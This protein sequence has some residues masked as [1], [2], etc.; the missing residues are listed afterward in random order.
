MNKK[1][2]SVILVENAVF[3]RHSKDKHFESSVE[4]VLFSDCPCKYISFLARK[5][6]A[7]NGIFMGVSASSILSA[8]KERQETSTL[9][10]PAK[11]RQREK[12]VIGRCCSR[13]SSSLKLMYRGGR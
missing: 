10:A 1:P 4:S 3:V 2:L 8:C 9:T 7:V 12:D 13:T 11:K 5:H 6:C